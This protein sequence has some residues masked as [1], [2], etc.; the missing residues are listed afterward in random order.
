[1]GDFI[2]GRGGFAVV[3]R[4]EVDGRA[5]ARKKLRFP[6][7]PEHLEMIQNE[8]H[9]LKAVKDKFGGHGH[10][11]IIDLLSYVYDGDKIVGYDME[12]GL[13]DLSRFLDGDFDKSLHKDVLRT[14]LT[15]TASGLQYVHKCGFVH[16]DVTTRNLLLMSNGN[17]K[18][19]DYGTLLTQGMDE[20]RFVNQKE[21][22][23]RCYPQVICRNAHP[24][25]MPWASRYLS[26]VAQ[27]IHDW[28]AFGTI[29][30][31]IDEELLL[32]CLLEVGFPF[33]RDSRLVPDVWKKLY[34]E[35]GHFMLLPIVMG[36]RPWS[37]D[38][39]WFS[40]GKFLSFGGLGGAS[41]LKRLA[42][43]FVN[44]ARNFRQEDVIV[45]PH[46]N[47]S[48]EF[49]RHHAKVFF[50]STPSVRRA[51][52]TLRASVFERRL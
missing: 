19:I 13:M 50:R 42:S 18:L 1:M 17:V 29:L 20:M 11:C 41:S 25:G 26:L 10:P 31:D 37:Q 3:T 33:D 8:A 7:N 22:W 45:V 43:K 47:A 24:S 52:R 46:P 15:H 51:R 30:Q 48:P 28:W 49:R 4:E 32:E 12:L 36:R 16:G 27:Y 35:V 9:F 23:L 14:M 6:N 38:H 44:S 39:T 2:L 34:Y 40:V 21:M 5:V